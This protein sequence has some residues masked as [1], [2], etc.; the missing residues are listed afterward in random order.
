MGAE[1]DESGIEQALKISS[2][3]ALDKHQESLRELRVEN[4]KASRLED[5]EQ[6]LAKI[7]DKQVFNAKL[8]NLLFLKLFPNWRFLDVNTKMLRVGRL[9]RNSVFGGED[10]NQWRMHTGG[11]A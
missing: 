10:Y 7:P 8:R 4:M 3:R 6:I 1:G 11:D 5:V 2:I 9:A